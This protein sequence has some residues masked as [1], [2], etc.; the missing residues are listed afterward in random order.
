MRSKKPS[1]NTLG[2]LI[3]GISDH[4]H[5]LIA[6]FMGPTWGLSGADRTQVGP[7]LATWT[8]LSGL[9]HYSDVTWAS[10]PLKCVLNSLF[11]PTARISGYHQSAT[12]ETFCEGNSPVT[13]GFP[14]QR[15]RLIERKRFCAV[16]SP[17]KSSTY[18]WTRTTEYSTF[19]LKIVCDTSSP[20]WLGI[21]RDT[22]FSHKLYFSISVPQKKWTRQ[23]ARIQG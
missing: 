2:C 21:V 14:S 3:H 10:W 13:S 19:S 9:F 20:Y 7:M 6:R 1:Q 8:L 15:T 16:T 12:V 22:S 18:P 11:S 5:T 23:R 4:R 17:E